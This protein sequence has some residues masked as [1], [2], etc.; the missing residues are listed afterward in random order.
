M[1]LPS[2]WAGR[3]AGSKSLC[4]LETAL[5][6]LAFFYT[7]LDFAYWASITDEK[8][9]KG[10]VH[11]A[12]FFRARDGA[13][14][15]TD[16]AFGI[17]LFVTGSAVRTG[18]AHCRSGGPNPQGTTAAPGAG[19]MDRLERDRLAESLERDGVNLFD[20]HERD[21]DHVREGFVGGFF[22]RLAAAGLDGAF[23][24]VQ[25]LPCFLLRHR[26]FGDGTRG[27]LACFR[28]LGVACLHAPVLQAPGWREGQ[29]LGAV[30][31]NPAQLHAR[32][33]L[34]RAV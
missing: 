32:T 21:R 34:A 10:V 8:D 19:D 18:L 28:R 1:L 33:G 6:A 20:F 14:M 15:L 27:R 12:S 2:S 29:E 5:A 16:G 17:A 4:V 31:P 26:G 24:S 23:P 30:V 22:L 25:L 13:Y 9:D 7:A 11:E 3:S